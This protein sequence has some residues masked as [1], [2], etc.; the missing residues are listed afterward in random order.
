MDAVDVILVLPYPYS[1]HPS[2]PE[3]ILKKALE[4]AGF[5]VGLIETPFW[6]DKRAFSALGRPKLFFAVVSGPM[7]SIVL[8]Y[9]ASRR[10]RREDLYQFDGQAFFP[11]H[12]RDI[13]F[14]IRPD[15]TTIVFANRLREA[16]RGTPLVIGGVEAGLR[17]FAHYDFQE[18]RIRRS[19]LLDSRADIL[20]HGSGEKQIVAIA[21][22]LRAG[23]P[24]EAID[25]PGTA[26]VW[27]R[28]PAEKDCLELP[29][30]EEVQADPTLLLRSQLLVERA[31]ATGSAL[32]QRAA[33]RWVV[34]NPAQTYRRPDLDFIYGL[35]YQRRHASAGAWT[36]A[37]RMNLFSVTAHRGCAG[38]CAFCS[39]SVS[40]GRRIVS[41]S[42]D[43]ILREIDLLAAHAQWRGVVSDVGGATA[44]MYGAD[45]D[46]PA[47]AR[48]SCLQPSSCRQFAPGEP[49]R[50]L[51]K[52]CRE[53]RAVK[54][55]LLGSGVRYDLLLKNPG[56]LEDLLRHHCGRF[57]RIAPEHTEDDILD[58]M[59]KPRYDV[60][61]E[62]VA[63]FRR[64]NRRMPR[65]IELAPY[66]IVGHPGETAAHVRAMAGKLRELGLPTTDVQ[67]FT[68]APGTLATAMYVSGLDA[69]GRPLAVE[70]D[71]R[72]LQRRKH[73]LAG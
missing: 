40:E 44:E 58:L 39:V 47:C 72:A 2:F 31:M 6:Q 56:L 35:P 46:D 51:L 15:R 65:P 25:I 17:C 53:R 66:L 21:G 16:F 41:R 63:L 64:L 22:L 55:V 12:A 3:G 37:L 26:K 24:A 32:A 69:Q 61:Q 36:P 57:L 28:L 4:A 49:Y 29:G 38:G 34:Q 10:R 14:K 67:I 62:F 19:V 70:R 9:T 52:Q 11:D 60:L 18:D 33:G 27:D 13:K 23:Q 48:T 5:T 71:V 59:G 20:V 1:D 7:D 50:L 54:Q 68:P 45:C 30:Q 42:P 8:N 73:V 43:S